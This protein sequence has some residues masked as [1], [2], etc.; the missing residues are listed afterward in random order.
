MNSANDVRLSRIRD[1]LRRYGKKRSTLY[2][3]I[4]RGEFP[5]PVKIG[6]RQSAWR[7]ADLSEWEKSLVEKKAGER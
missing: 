2:A 6:V 1:V 5:P 3:E 7:E 4:Q